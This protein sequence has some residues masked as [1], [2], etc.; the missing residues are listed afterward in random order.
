MRRTIT[1]F[2]VVTGV[3]LTLATCAVA[4]LIVVET[5]GY[6]V[7]ASQDHTALG[8][9]VTSTTMENSVK[10]RASDITEPRFTQ[11]MVVQGGASTRRCAPDA[12][13]ARAWSR[14]SGLRECCLNRQT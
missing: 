10:S 3:F 5:G 1:P 2:G 9:W 8:R 12:T 14:R 7:A 4:G 6:N 11:A 13:V